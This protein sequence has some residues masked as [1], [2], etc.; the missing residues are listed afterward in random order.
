ME[1]G[2]EGAREREKKQCREGCSLLA[3]S[4]RS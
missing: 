3:L 2:R 1:R 4:I